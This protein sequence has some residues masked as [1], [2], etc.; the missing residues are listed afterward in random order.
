MK[1]LSTLLL[2]HDYDNIFRYLCLESHFSNECPPRS[3]DFTTCEFFLWSYLKSYVYRSQPLSLT[4]LKDAKDHHIS[5]IPKFSLKK[6]LKEMFFDAMQAIL[7]RVR[8]GIYKWRVSY[9]K[10]VTLGYPFFLF[11]EFYRVISNFTINFTTTSRQ[12][13]EPI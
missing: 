7:H 3:S 2:V 5:E 8:N 9:R 13:Y 1:C 10:V 6:V 11:R 12:K 4:Q